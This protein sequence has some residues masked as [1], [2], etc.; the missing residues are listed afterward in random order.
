[1]A[2]ESLQMN[3]ISISSLVHSPLIAFTACAAL[4]AFAGPSQG[5]VA[6]SA[7]NAKPLTVGAATPNVILQSLSGKD[8]SLS[9]LLKHK[10][11]VLIFYRGGWCPFCNVHLSDLVTIEHKITAKGFQIIAISPDTPA[12]LSKTLTKDHLTYKLYSDSAAEAMKKFG[13]AYRL[14]DDTFFKMKNDYGVDLEKSSGKAHH[15][16]PVPSV[17]VIGKDG[18]IA[19][20]HS[21]PDYKVRLKASEI[22]SVI[23]GM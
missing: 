16:L 14:D 7:A 15:I 23:D 18:K 10:R 11:T 12:E 3:P 22:L 2:T 4:T 21:N 5:I 20:V 17:F 6:D 8:V 19:Y 9:S 1:M 13:V